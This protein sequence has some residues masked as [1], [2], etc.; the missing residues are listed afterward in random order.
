MASSHPGSFAP[1]LSYLLV[2][3]NDG[4]QHVHRSDGLHVG[5]LKRV[6]AVWKFKAMGYDVSGAVEPGG[7]PLTDCHNTT[8]AEADAAAVN[9]GLAPKAT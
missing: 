6:G 8:F 4:V 1:R 3:A 5:N 2:S 9:A 7:G